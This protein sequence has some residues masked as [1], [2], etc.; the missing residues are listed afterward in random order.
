MIDTDKYEGLYIDDLDG[1]VTLF[2]STEE[3]TE[4]IAVFDE[5]HREVIQNLLAEVKRCHEI[6]NASSTLKHISKMIEEVKRLQK[7]SNVLE[8]LMGSLDSRDEGDWILLEYID[9]LMKEEGIARWSE[10]KDK[11]ETNLI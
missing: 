6:I 7:Y 9:E 1:A 3:G 2:K 4:T 5:E 8:K 10:E 11:T